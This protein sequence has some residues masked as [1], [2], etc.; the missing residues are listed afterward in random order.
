MKKI[1]IFFSLIILC[2]FINSSE[3]IDDI[4]DMFLDIGNSLEIEFIQNG[5][6]YLINNNHIIKKIDIELAYRDTEKI[7]GLKYRSFLKENRG[8]LF[9]FKHQEEYKQMNMKNV[10]IP[11]DIIYI[12]QFD[13]VIF[14]NQYVPP[15]RD[16]EKITNFPSNTSIKYILEINAGMSNKWGIKEGVTKITW[17]IK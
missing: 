15:M 14:V 5:K 10:Q 2:F 1:L 8:M 16:I 4:S 3:R 7:N 9:L 6:L 12:N 11:L 17:F 13:T